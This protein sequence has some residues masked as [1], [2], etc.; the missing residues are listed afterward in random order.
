MKGW[1]WVCGGQV[2][3]EE[4][5]PPRCGVGVQVCR[6]HTVGV[7]RVGESSLRRCWEQTDPP[8]GCRGSEGRGCLWRSTPPA[9]SHP[10]V[11]SPLSDSILGEQALTVTDDKVSVL[12]LQVQPVMGIALALSRGTAHPGE[13]TATCW[14]QSAPPTPKQV[15]AG[16][17]RDEVNIFRWGLMMGGMGGTSSPHPRVSRTRT[18]CAIR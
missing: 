14:A 6:G 16:G 15:T 5:T 7:Q 12:E 17:Q 1:G 11:R 2:L 13:V 10:Q 8:V 3:R 9:P 18:D 4:E